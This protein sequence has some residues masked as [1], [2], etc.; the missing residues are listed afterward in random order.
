MSNYKTPENQNQTVAGSDI[1]DIVL[2]FI[3]NYRKLESSTY[4]EA[5]R[6]IKQFSEAANLSHQYDHLCSH[7]KGKQKDFGSFFMNLGTPSQIRILHS[8]GIKD[9]DDKAYLAQESDPVR[10]LFA[11]RPETLNRILKVLVFFNN[12]GIESFGPYANLPGLHLTV[13][14]Q[15]KKRY[16]NSAN[17][18][19]Y[20]LS[21]V[22]P[23]YVLNQI[24]KYSEASKRLN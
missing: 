18:G 4:E 19:S 8:W 5:F 7:W 6:F 24:F 1:T 13:L 21:L 20:V 14:P 10:F 22:S 9:L 17:W 16:G 12:H 15:T 2:N 3:R 23:E 11:K